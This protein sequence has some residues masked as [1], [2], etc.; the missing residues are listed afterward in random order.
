MGVGKHRAGAVRAVLPPA[1]QPPPVPRRSQNRLD[2]KHRDMV[3]QYHREQKGGIRMA[4]PRK[5][6]DE[7]GRRYSITLDAEARYSLAKL[8]EISGLNRSQIIRW[9][10]RKLWREVCDEAGIEE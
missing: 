8:T 5:S 4:P 2:S 7:L 1:R 3:I 6:P 9:A 10:L